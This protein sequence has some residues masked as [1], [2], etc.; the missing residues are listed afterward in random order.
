MKTPFKQNWH[1]VHSRLD[2]SAVLGGLKIE[3]PPLFYFFISPHTDT[4]AAKPLLLSCSFTSLP[5]DH[6]PQKQCGRCGSI[7]LKIFPFFISFFFF[8]VSWNYFD[9]STPT[10]SC[11]QKQSTNYLGE[12][13]IEISNVGKE[14]PVSF[15]F[16]ALRDI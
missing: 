15:T 2:L 5:G 4:T 1:L 13:R 8:S 10:L 7:F 3:T 9:L 12:N 14:M 11:R 16:C 6:L